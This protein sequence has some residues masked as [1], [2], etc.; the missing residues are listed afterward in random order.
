L[1]GVKIEKAIF[2]VKAVLSQLPSQLPQDIGWLHPAHQFFIRQC[3]IFG[4]RQMWVPSGDVVIS[5][6]IRQWSTP[7]PRSAAPSAF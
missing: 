3:V 6:A 7:A 5:I 2:Y 4:V 1:R